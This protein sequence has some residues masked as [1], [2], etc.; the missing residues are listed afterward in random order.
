[1]S[2][3]VLL[4]AREFEKILNRLGFVKL[5][6]KGSHAIY[7]HSDGRTVSVPFHSSKDLSRSLLRDLLSEINVSI[8]EYNKLINK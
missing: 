6:M 7:R 5:R 1:M 4:N 3:L 2:K 8:D